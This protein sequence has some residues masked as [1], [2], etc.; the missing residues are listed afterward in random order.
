M[1]ARNTHNYGPRR[2]FSTAIVMTIAVASVAA[3]GDRHHI[4][5][6]GGMFSEPVNWLDSIPPGAPIPRPEYQK[7]AS[8]I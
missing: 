3:A 8:N 5:P 1:R 6:A 4:N 2:F 7:P